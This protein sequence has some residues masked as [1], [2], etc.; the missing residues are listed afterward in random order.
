MITK[1]KTSN[2]SYHSTRIALEGNHIDMKLQSV[3]TCF[4]KYLQLLVHVLVILLKEMPERALVLLFILIYA[5]D[6]GSRF[7]LCTF[8]IRI[9]CR[10]DCKN[11]CSA[12]FSMQHHSGV[13]IIDCFT[14]N[15]ITPCSF[16]TQCFGRF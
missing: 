7:T 6:L 16:Q 5:E 4:C 3:I 1:D 2:T 10:D 11:T 8:Y 12:E 13:V 9:L 14:D 15:R